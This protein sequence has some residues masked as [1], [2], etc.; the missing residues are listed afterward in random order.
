MNPRISVVVAT[1]RPGAGLD[2][3]LASL[4]AQ[5][6]PARDFEVVFVDDGSPD[7]TFERLQRLERERANVRAVRI[8]NS[9]WPSR[10]RNVGIE[11][12]RGDYV[13]FM[14]HDDE[15]YP[16]GLR[17][18]LALADRAGSDVVNGKESRTS[19]AAWGL[20]VFTH[21]R[22]HAE[23]ETAPHALTPMT[24]HKLYRRQLLMDHGIRFPEGARQYYE[25][26]FFNIDVAAHARVISV[27]AETPFYHWVHTGDNSSLAF[28]ADLAHQWDIV[29]RVF[30]RIHSALGDERHAATRDAL[31]AQ[32]FQD[33][34]LGFFG[35]G[36]DTRADADV[37]V[38]LGRLPRVLDLVPPRLDARF[39][40]L[41]RLRAAAVRRGDVPALRALAAVDADRVGMTTAT[42][43]RWHDD[44][45]VVDAETSWGGPLA[46]TRENG[47]WWRVDPAGTRQDATAELAAATTTVVLGSEDDHV[48]WPS[49]TQ[50][51]AA[52][53]DDGEVTLTSRSHIDVGR[54]AGGRPLPAHRWKPSSLT[55]LGGIH[56]QRHVRYRGPAA[57]GLVQGRAVFA[58][59]SPAGYLWLEIGER[60]R[61][62]IAEVGLDVES[63]RVRGGTASVPLRGVHTHGV[64]R[65]PGAVRFTSLP[66]RGRRERLMRL[67]GDLLGRVPIVATRA[68]QRERECAIVGDDLGARWE[69]TLP[70]WPGRYAVTAIAEGREVATGVVVVRSPSGV[71]RLTAS[72]S[73]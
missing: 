4:D 14:D 20:A 26:L 63:A 13:L 48:V 7:A 12:A 3:V 1:Y 45:L 32:R 68:R 70:R 33:W 58:F 24:P 37:S 66:P 5:T 16:D 55:R 47:R 44:A 65:L 50:A 8:E 56:N 71:V 60:R 42:A 10:P 15:L 31:L 19:S 52:V 29:V 67:V 61:S 38:V 40:A 64:T 23:H 49:R 18:A 2:R 41:Q 39:D 43:L 28:D 25:D 73:R 22:A 27:L 34:V 36:F 54:A 57:V 17:A 72:S 9:G 53:S 62:V 30:E 35:R 59:G 51:T 21:D 46:V 6:L 11:M 69:L